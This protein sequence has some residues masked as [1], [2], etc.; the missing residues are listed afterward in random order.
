MNKTAV[1]LV[2]A[3]LSGCFSAGHA[4]KTGKGGLQTACGAAC[5]EYKTDGTG[6][7]KFQEGTAQTCTTYF[8][9]ICKI[10]PAQCKN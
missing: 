7:A 10:E 3:L 4:G 9:K 1:I 8:E 5:T 6:C 2:V